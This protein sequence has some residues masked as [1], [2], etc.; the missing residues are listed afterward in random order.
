MFR[1]GA[2]YVIT[3]RVRLDGAIATGLTRGSPDLLIAVGV[4][5]SI[6]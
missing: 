4:T 3:E 5:I 1:G 6:R 2:V